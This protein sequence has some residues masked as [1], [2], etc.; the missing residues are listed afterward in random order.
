MTA[1]TLQSMTLCRGIQVP[2]HVLYADDMMIFCKA[3][4]KNIQQLLHIFNLYGQVS[5]QLI[6]KQKSKFYAGSISNARL[7]TLTNLLGFTSGSLPFTYLGCPIFM[8][9]PKQIHLRALADRI[10]TKLATWKG[11]LLSIM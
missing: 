4:K 9:K 2:S 6:N 5:G 7:V 11:S 8:G 3:S 10:K 1:G